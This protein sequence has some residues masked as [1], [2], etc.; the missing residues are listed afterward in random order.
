MKLV[1]SLLCVLFTVCV[2]PFLAGSTEDTPAIGIVERLGEMVPLDIQ[3]LDEDG[4]TVSLKDF[5]G[6]P[7]ILSL[8]YYSCPGICAPLLNGV[9]DVLDKVALEPGK[10]F[11]VV[12]IS[13]DAT[14]SPDLAKNKKENYLKTFN[15]P[16]DE[17]GWHFLTGDQENIDRIT[18]A[19]GFHYKKEGAEFIHTAAIYILSPEG[20]IT[21]YLYGISFLPFDLKLAVLEGAQ[22]KVGPTIARVLLYCFS[23]DPAGQTY[24]FNVLKVTGTVTMFVAVLFVI[25]LVVTTRRHRT[26][27]KT[28]A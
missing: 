23:Y 25:W 3:F 27:E 18:R 16:F 9:A 21:R 14:E 6:K 8:V 7:V 20:K 4:D 15:R 28:N 22:G 1:K 10:D 17:N 2:C 13:F 19:V 24:V 5:A 12:T 26:R 11:N